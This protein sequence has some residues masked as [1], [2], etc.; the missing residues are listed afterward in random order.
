MKRTIAAIL[1]FT[2]AFFACAAAAAEFSGATPLGS[3]SARIHNIELAASHINGV[4][5]RYGEQF[6]F[7]DV[8]GPR[9]KAYGYQ[10]APNGRGAKVTGGGVAQVASTLYL[11]LKELGDCVEIDRYS[12]YGGNFTGNYVSS[13][14]DAILVDYAAGIDFCFTCMVNALTIDMWT[15]DDALRCAIRVDDGAN[16]APA[17]ADFFA[18]VPMNAEGVRLPIA[19]ARI[20]VTDRGSLY[21][22]IA[23]AAETIN[24]TVLP[25]GGVFSF[26]EIVGPRTE[27]CG[28]KNALNGRG[29]TVVGGGV[30]Q[31]AS[32]LW[33]A[34]K[35][36]DCVSIVQKSTYGS[37]YNQTYVSSSNDAILTDYSGNTDFSF[38]NTGD[39]QLVISMELSGDALVCRIYQE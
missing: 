23:L 32:V 22:N 16:G 28:Y 17:A 12:T 33:L 3:G 4:T 2:M 6:S 7:N 26:N 24:D 13:S 25:G 30:A 19:S 11:A 29:V 27:R 20:E 1:V 31:V 39:A 35:N 38:R 36:L 18:F 34:V 9:T 10:T 15:T 8:V 21:N 37:R 14:S 5:L